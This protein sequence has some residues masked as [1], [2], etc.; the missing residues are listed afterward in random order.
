TGSGVN[1]FPPAPKFATGTRFAPGGTAV[2]GERGPELVNLPRGSQVVPTIPSMKAL[3]AGIPSTSVTYAPQIDARGADAAAVARLE[4]V[5]ARDRAEFESK[6]VAAI[7]NARS[8]G[9]KGV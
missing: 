5:M 2:V 1:Y 9:V 7:R 4:Q 6:T 8:R 3:K